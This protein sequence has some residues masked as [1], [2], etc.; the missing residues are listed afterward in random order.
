MFYRVLS[1]L[2][3][4]CS[5]FWFHLL[6]FVF[7]GLCTVVNPSSECGIGSSQASREKADAKERQLGVRFKARSSSNRRDM[8]TRPSCRSGEF[9]RESTHSLTLSSIHSVLVSP[10]EHTLAS[11]EVESIKSNS[12]TTSVQ[13]VSLLKRSCTSISLK[14]K[15]TLQSNARFY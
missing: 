11:S 15:I 6:V 10:S 14:R 4:F 7:F 1:C 2:F 3:F 5:Q 12:E 13:E 9:E 8:C